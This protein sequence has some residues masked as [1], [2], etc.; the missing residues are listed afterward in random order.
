MKC[1]LT[2]LLISLSFV[3]TSYSQTDALKKSIERGSEIYSDFCVS[4]HLPNGKG[5][6]RTYPPLAKS[7]YLFK[8]REGSIKAIK[9]GMQGKIVVNG[10]TYNS[11]MTPMGLTNNEVA[12]VL[13]YINNSWGNKNT[14]IATE[15]EVSKIKK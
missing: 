12:D 5:V 4:C 6:G 7:D 8:N 3:Y 10:V 11:M 1:F 2:T 15:A 14:K 9:Y 13:N